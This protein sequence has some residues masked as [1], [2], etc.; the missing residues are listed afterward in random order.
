MVAVVRCTQAGDQGFAQR[1]L[2]IRVFSG[3]FPEEEYILDFDVGFEL[4]FQADASSGSQSD[5][6]LIGLVPGSR[7]FSFKG[8]TPRNF[9][10]MNT[11]ARS[12]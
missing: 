12:G 7:S 6:S 5:S 4:S 9:P 11:L 3:D 10:S 1:N 8:V 2:G